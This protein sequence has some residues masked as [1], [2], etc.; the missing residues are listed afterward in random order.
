MKEHSDKIDYIKTIYQCDFERQMATKGTE[1]HQFFNSDESELN[2]KSKKPEQMIIREGLRG[3][4]VEG[5][6]MGA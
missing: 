4:M 1:I 3:G 6:N 2:P 5:F